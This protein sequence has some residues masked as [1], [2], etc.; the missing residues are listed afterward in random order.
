MTTISISLSFKSLNHQILNMTLISQWIN[1]HKP[2]A[3]VNVKLQNE[4]LID[5][6]T[7]YNV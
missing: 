5:N 6:Y 4:E 1:N 2:A 7:T 3:T